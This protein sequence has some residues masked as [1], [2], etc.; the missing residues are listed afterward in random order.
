[1]LSKL[2]KVGVRKKERPRESFPEAFM[3]FL[4]PNLKTRINEASSF[5]LDTILHSPNISGKGMNVTRFHSKSYS[6]HEGAE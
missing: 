6:N 5:I 3:A 2:S 4:S 1:M